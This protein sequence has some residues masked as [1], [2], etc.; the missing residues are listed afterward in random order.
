MPKN[1]GAAG[2]DLDEE[3]DDNEGEASEYT[4]LDPYQGHPADI[5]LLTPTRESVLWQ[6]VKWERNPHTESNKDSSKLLVIVPGHHL[7]RA[8]ITAVDFCASLKT[9]IYSQFYKLD[10]TLEAKTPGYS[11]VKKRKARSATR[12]QAM[13]KKHDEEN[14][15]VSP[16]RLIPTSRPAQSPQQGKNLE[17]DVGDKEEMT[18]D[19]AEIPIAEPLRDTS[20]FYSNG[21]PKPGLGQRPT[22]APTCRRVV[23]QGK[24]GK[25]SK[26]KGRRR[27]RGSAFHCL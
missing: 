17:E 7:L 12:P 24:K 26:G 5:R 16:K 2:C 23:C 9:N 19:P 6:D 8:N 11:L 22:A 15:K 10:P 13:D 18:K 3:A 25:K 21:Q 27:F 4:N 1:L 20:L 14:E